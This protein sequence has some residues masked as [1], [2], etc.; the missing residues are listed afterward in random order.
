MKLIINADDYGYTQ[1]INKGII[2]GH[3]NGIISSTTVLTNSPNLQQSYDLVKECPQLGLG[4]HLTL[5]LGKPLTQGHS[6]TDQN[7]YFF[8]RKEINL[9]IMDKKEIY[10]E[11]KSQIELF[12]QTFNQYPTHLDSHHSVHDQPETFA[13]TQYLCQEYNLTCRRHSPAKFIGNFFGANI[14]VDFIIETL[15]NNINEE[16]IEIMT[17]A[18]FSDQELR[19]LSSYNDDREKELEILCDKTLIRY[20]EENNIALINYNQC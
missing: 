8:N 4:V 15:K 11:W 18:G 3:K 14:T 1:G 9:S 5:T 7:G 6:L 20:I 2:H 10:N 19:D 16:C 17:H 13:I 12:I